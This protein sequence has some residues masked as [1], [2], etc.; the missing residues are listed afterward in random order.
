MLEKK[1]ILHIDDDAAVSAV[2]AEVLRIDN[3]HVVS[4]YN[5][6]EGIKQIKSCRPD[7]V[8]LDLS[9]PGMSGL[10]VL[11]KVASG[12][13]VRVVP[14]L[15]YTA[16]TGMADEEVRELATGVIAKPATADALLGAVAAALEGR[17]IE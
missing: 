12:D 4:A 15:V 1:I 14:V 8:L 5:A 10:T 9:M 6:Q 13:G 3:Y 2:T 16:F 7:L 11:R 17:P